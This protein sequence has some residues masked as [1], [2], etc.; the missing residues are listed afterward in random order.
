MDDVLLSRIIRENPIKN[1]LDTFRASFSS[2][3]E[4]ANVSCTLDALEQLS[5]K[6]LALDLLSTLQSLRASRLLRSSGR[7]KNL[8]SE[9]SRLNSVVNSDDFNLDH[10][11]PL[12]KSAIADN[13]DDAQ[14]W[15]QAYRADVDRVLR[16]ELGSIYVGLP[17]FHEAF[18]GL[19]AG[20]KTASE[21]IFKKCMEGSEPL[22]SNRWSG[23]PTD[24]NQ[25][26]VLSWFSELSEKLATFAEGYRS[27]ST[28]RRPLAQPNKPIRGSTAERKLDVNFVD[29]PKAG[30]ESRCHWSQILVPGELK[31]NPT[32]D[33]SVKTWLSISTSLMR[34]WEFD[35]L[36][37][38]TSELFDINK[39]GLQFVST[40]LGFLWTS[41]EEL[42]FDPTIRTANDKRFIDIE[43]DGLTERLI[44][45]EVMQRARYIAGR[46]TTYWK[47]HRKG[48]PQTPLVIKDSWQYSERDKEGELLREATG[49]GVVNV[50]RYYYHETVE[51][52]GTDDDIRR[53]IRGGLDVTTT[54]NYRPERSMPPPSIIASGASR[55]GRSNSRATGKKQSSSQINVPLPPSKRS[56]S[57]SPTKASG[58]ALSNRV[59]RRIIIRDYGNSIYQASSRSALLSP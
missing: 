36:G 43:H 11:K 52:H 44:I 50:A 59:H 34:I 37:G 32:A 20:L 41:E 24:A 8:F 26:D 39:D 53:S 3:C 4:G 10:I 31:S 46:A 27:I 5:Q 48:H 47:A 14:I 2:A 56:Y 16:D 9:L 51:V 18:F 13:P 40:V 45:D 21:A 12:L 57:A 17:R 54:I 33:T 28:R 30:K 55:G 35:R 49:Q 25:D 22:F 58:D 42:G 1:G 29:E 38:I 15:D 6:D 7:G 19:V 23:W